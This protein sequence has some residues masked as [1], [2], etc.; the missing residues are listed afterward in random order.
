M[1]HLHPVMGDQSVGE[2]IG[3]PFKNQFLSRPRQRVLPAKLIFNPASGRP[4]QSAGQLMEI[5]TDMQAW[6]I[7]PEVTIVRPGARL[8]EITADAIRR[9]M[10]LIVVGGGD[11]T[12]DAVAGALVGSQAVLGVI[13]T[14]TRNNVALSL[15]IPTGNLAE[16]VATLRRGRRIH[17]DVG[18]AHCGHTQRHFIE[19]GTVGLISALYPAADDI[20]HGNLIR[21][22][23]LLGTWVSTPPAEI[24]LNLDDGREKL[25]TQGHI[26]LIANMPYFGVNF[27]L[28]PDI[29]YDDGLLD[30]FVY[31]NLTKLDLIGYAVQMA[32]G[33]PEDTRVQH[34]RVRNL[35]VRTIPRMPVMADGTMLGEGPLKVTVVHS[36]LAV[37]AGMSA[38]SRTIDR[39]LSRPENL[40]NG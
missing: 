32:G 38:V 2:T 26:V 23:D 40:P 25:V 4:D 21:I 22:G 3:M 30:V 39:Q 27:H 13:P 31:S 7:L 17:V 5:L 9:G 19:A 20:Q 6:H 33:L 11:G 8:E 24:H 1:S 29:S 28:A 37:M 34:F 18:C 10:R 35:T 16:A 36:G 14:G 12:I 15:G